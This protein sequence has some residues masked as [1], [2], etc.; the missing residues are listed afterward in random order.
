MGW[1]ADRFWD[2]TPTEFALSVEAFDERESDK[3][4]RLAWHAANIMNMWR[5]KKSRAIRVA[6]LL[7]EPKHEAPMFVDRNDL[8]EYMRG[9]ERRR[10]LRERRGD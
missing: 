2:S 3:M 1:T 6:D 5:G 9:K 8:L 4:R 7:S 10:R